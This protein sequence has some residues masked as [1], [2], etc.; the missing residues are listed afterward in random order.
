MQTPRA[1]KILGLASCG[2]L[3][4]ATAADP[5]PFAAS[6]Q[7]KYYSYTGKPSQVLHCPGES[8]N[9]LIGRHYD[10]GRWEGGRWCGQIGK[11][12]YWVYHYPNWYVWPE[13]R[14]VDSPSPPAAGES[15][16]TVG[17]RYSELVAQIP[18]PQNRR[19][20]QP[21]PYEWG[22]RWE[23]RWCGEYAK[24]YWVYCYPQWYVWKRRE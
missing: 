1:A 18:C 12:G 16:A 17:G 11:P 22:K 20:F 19:T 4:V 24:G 15:D 7:G 8:T 6:E 5:L 23:G 2:W 14:G 10:Y 3:A 21:Q 9:P 13:Q